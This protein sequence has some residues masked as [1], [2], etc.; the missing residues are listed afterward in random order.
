MSSITKTF[1]I[2]RY[3]E[4][5][6]W[7]LNIPKNINIYV[8][9]KSDT[10]PD[11]ILDQSNIHY[12]FLDDI[13]LAEYAYFYHIVKHYDNLYGNLYFTQADF[14]DH[15]IDYLS[16]VDNNMLG[17]LS[18]FNI[19]T[20]IFGE[21]QGTYHKHINHKYDGG[22]CYNDVKDK[23]FLDPWND[24]EAIDNINYII[25]LL[26]ELNIKKEN[27]IFNANGLYGANADNLKQIHLDT[28]KKCLNAFHNKPSTI[29]MVPYAFERL[30]K[31][32]I[33]K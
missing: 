10:V 2:N 15:S 7:V 21:N 30:N 29:N 22:C 24:Q 31:F 12:E 17:G 11:Y 14:T 5:I 33:L 13:G 26:P 32:I 1:I 19:I 16:K 3:K 28:F 23:I 8:Y 9:N 18:D 20:T 25:N 4:N 27:W 6:E